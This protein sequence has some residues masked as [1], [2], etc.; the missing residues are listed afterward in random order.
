MEGCFVLNSFFDCW[1]CYHNQKRGIVFRVD[2]ERCWIFWDC[3]KRDRTRRDVF[4]K[5]LVCGLVECQATL[6]S[7]TIPSMQ[8]VWKWKLV[9]VIFQ[10][11][12]WT[13]VMDKERNLWL[14]EGLE[15]VMGI[16]TMMVLFQ[17]RE[18]NAFVT[19]LLIHVI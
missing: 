12:I 15:F 8:V 18:S 13:S 9:V 2:V 3:V 16:V 1:F 7:H 11:S 6:L 10:T 5:D 4:I 14:Y 19:W 17:L